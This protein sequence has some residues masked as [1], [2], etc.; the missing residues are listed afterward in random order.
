MRKD[1]T[2]IILCHSGDLQPKVTCKLLA[3]K[4][5]CLQWKNAYTHFIEYILNFR[6][7]T[8]LRHQSE[9]VFTAWSGNKQDWLAILWSGKHISYFA[10]FPV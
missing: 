3:I 4:A 6:G 1:L 8:G 7:V 5:F 9:Y 10:I 2:E